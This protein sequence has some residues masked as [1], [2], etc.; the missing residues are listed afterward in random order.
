MD[1][2]F[3]MAQDMSFDTT[4]KELK[5]IQLCDSIVGLQGMPKVLRI[6]SY[7]NFGLSEDGTIRKIGSYGGI[8]GNRNNQ[9]K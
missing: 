4:E 3:H 1:Y 5:W 6:L 9:H 8:Y 2:Y 7:Q